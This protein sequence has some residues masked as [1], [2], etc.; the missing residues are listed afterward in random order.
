MTNAASLVSLFMPVILENNQTWTVQ[1]PAVSLVVRAVDLSL[2]TLNHAGAGS[3]DVIGPVTGSGGISGN[4]SGNLVIGGTNTFTGTVTINS[5]TLTVLSSGALGSPGAGTFIGTAGRLAMDLPGG[6][7][8]AE[9]MIVAGRVEMVTGVTNLWTG[10]VTLAG[11]QVGFDSLNLSRLEIHGPLSGTTFQTLNLGTVVLAGPSSIAG[12][13]RVGGNSRLLVNTPHSGVTFV[14]TNGGR[15]GGSGP[16][17]GL[18]AVNCAGCE[19]QPGP[20]NAPGRIQSTTARLDGLAGLR[21]E[22]NGPTPITEYDQWRI[23]GTLALTNASLVVT[24]SFDPAEGVSFRIIDNDDGEPAQGTFNNLPEGALLTNGAVILQISYGGGDGNDVTLTRVTAAPPSQLAA[25][26][27]S[28]G[29][30][31]VAGVGLPNLPYVLEATEHLNAPIP[32]QPILT[33]T[34]DGLGAY[35]FLDFGA[36]NVP[37]RFYRV[38]SP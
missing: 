24:A 10:S 8:L 30:P 34:A 14:L 12:P 13:V 29:V 6:G 38:L 11:A 4:A 27:L 26:S 3:L 36:T 15:L 37:M 16:V 18:I 33:N 1:P 25:P 32:W 22:L 5:G 17:G 2:A 20:V 7:A 9:P 35:L 21:V 28:N 31:V 23:N 19:V